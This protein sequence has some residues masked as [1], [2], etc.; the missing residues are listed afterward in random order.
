M[1]IPEFI[2]ETAC[3]SRKKRCN[4]LAR[5]TLYS[6][7]TGCSLSKVE[8]G[9]YPQLLFH[10]YKPISRFLECFLWGLIRFVR[11][12]HSTQAIPVCSSMVNG[13]GFSNRPLRVCVSLYLFFLL[14]L[15]QSWQRRELAWTRRK[16]E[17][18]ERGHKGIAMDIKAKYDRRIWVLKVSELIEE[19]RKKLKNDCEGAG[20]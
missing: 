18:E 2:P 16:G 1:G 5:R 20:K 12:Y 15:S 3:N 17:R 10:E 14:L 19:E 7:A 13:N 11:V 4:S 6:C 8:V 9:E